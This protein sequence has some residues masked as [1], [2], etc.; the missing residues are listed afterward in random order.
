MQRNEKPTATN[1]FNVAVVLRPPRRFFVDPPREQ[2][3]SKPLPSQVFSHG[4]HCPWQH[5]HEDVQ[6]KD[7]LRS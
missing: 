6:V 1:T 4:C 7:Q 3:G 5:V 2:R